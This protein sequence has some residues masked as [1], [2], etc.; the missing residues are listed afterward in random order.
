LLAGLI[1]AAWAPDYFSFESWI[2]EKFIF[3]TRIAIFL[4]SAF[5]FT[6][7]G[8]SL[9]ART[10]IVTYEDQQDEERRL[11]RTRESRKSR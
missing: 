4:I 9:K 10:W 5:I 8:A 7:I 3:L 11:E 2:E 1:L 6:L